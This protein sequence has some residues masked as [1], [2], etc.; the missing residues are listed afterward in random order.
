MGYWEIT[1]NIGN[2]FTQGSGEY[3]S[4]Y[5]KGDPVE[6]IFENTNKYIN[7]FWNTDDD[8]GNS[9]SMSITSVD[10][11]IQS[12][13]DEYITYTKSQTSNSINVNFS[14]KLPLIFNEEFKVDYVETINN[15]QVQ[16]KN[17]L[18]KNVPS[19]KQ[20]TL[21]RDENFIDAN[22]EIISTTDSINWL[23]DY[24]ESTIKKVRVSVT[25]NYKLNSTPQTRTITK[26]IEY[27]KAQNSAYSSGPQESD[28]KLFIGSLNVTNERVIHDYLL[29]WIEKYE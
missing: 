29:D 9:P 19:G 13:F 3:S 14:G 5:S 1:S 23:T 15:E 2:T 12:P 25:V 28:V 24:A 16:T 6:I 26:D 18:L 17:V 7:L 27:I 20:L 4:S 22:S 10:V 21:I 8:G 11:S